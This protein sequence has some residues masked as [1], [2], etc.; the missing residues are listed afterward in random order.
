MKHA[1]HVKHIIRISVEMFC[2]YMLT[3][4]HMSIHD[5]WHVETCVSAK[6]PTYKGISHCMN[7]HISK[8]SHSIEAHQHQQGIDNAD[9]M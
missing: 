8:H 2:A 4:K 7:G 5:H 6:T 9:M 3:V 1:E